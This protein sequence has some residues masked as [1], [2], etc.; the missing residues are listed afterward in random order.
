ME[1][2]GSASRGELWN[3][4]RKKALDLVANLEGIDTDR[5]QVHSL[6]PHLLALQRLEGRIV[7]GLSGTLLLLTNHKLETFQNTWMLS[8][9]IG[10]TPSACCP[11][12]WTRCKICVWNKHFWGG[13]AY[14]ENGIKHQLHVVS[15]V[16]QL[17]RSLSTGHLDQWP[18]TS[19][20]I[21]YQ[22]LKRLEGRILIGLSGTLLLLTNHKLERFSN[23]RMP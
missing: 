18:L 14:M 1:G 4:N 23:T 6:L 15:R 20:P 8:A 13:G 21:F 10:G 19:D 22:W 2:T 5:A 3:L 9:D 12:S 17:S 11:A 16:E 7:T